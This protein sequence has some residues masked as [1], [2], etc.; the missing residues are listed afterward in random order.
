MYVAE[1]LGSFK[2][3]MIVF[4]VYMITIEMIVLGFKKCQVFL[5]QIR[6]ISLPLCSD[7]DRVHHWSEACSSKRLN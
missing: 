4:Y 3:F 7:I 5:Y 6:T 2:I 1:D